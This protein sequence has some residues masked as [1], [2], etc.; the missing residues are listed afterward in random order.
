MKTSRLI[1]GLAI[2]AVAL[3]FTFRDINFAAFAEALRTATWPWF[4]ASAGTL[5][6]VLV[7]RAARWSA[8]MGG[9]PLWVTFHAL[10]IGYMMNM[11]LP[12]R[13]GEIGR[14]FVIGERTPVSMAKAVSAV[15]VE[16]LLDLASVVL[17]L[18]GVAPFLPMPP[19]LVRPAAVSGVLVLVLIAAIGVMI[20]QAARFERLLRAV[21]G[22]LPA[23]D[24]EPWVKRFQD[25]CAGFRMLGSPSRLFTVLG[26]TV[27]VWIVSLF[28][29]FFVMLAFL[30]PM[31]EASTLVVIVANLGGVIPTPGGLGPA[32]Y[33]AKLAL[34]PFGVDETRG[35][36][37]VFVWWIGQLLLLVLLGF[38]G[39]FRVG[40]S[41][42]QLRGTTQKD[43]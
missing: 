38:V 25:L 10:N 18:A 8:I 23:I 32:Q 39:L 5:F 31:F 7:L 2:A 34:T 28:I 41:F 1:I 22:R 26:L 27:A 24:P 40:M 19:E 33:F 29:A 35:V 15:V 16:R 36:A 21:L 30:P 3:Y 20:W 4:L 42:G 14:A 17:M 11:L 6:F 43:Q 37:F 13:L 12:G 9:T